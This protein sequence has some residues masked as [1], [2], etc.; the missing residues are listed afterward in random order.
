MVY[1]FSA[2]GSIARATLYAVFVFSF[3]LNVSL[4]FNLLVMQVSRYFILFLSLLLVYFDCVVRIP[5]LSLAF[6]H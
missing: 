1:V 4:R 2:K 5:H 6:L 3:S